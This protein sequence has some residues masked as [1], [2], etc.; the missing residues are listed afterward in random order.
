MLIGK[1]HAQ[2]FDILGSG[3][4]DN[5]FSDSCWTYNIGPT[6]RLL[7]EFHDVLDIYFEN[8][9]VVWVVQHEYGYPVE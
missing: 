2:V 5:S 3:E 9:K 7:R 4:G 8:G 6:P 1:T